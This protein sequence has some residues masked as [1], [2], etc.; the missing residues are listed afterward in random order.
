M[1][2]K[3]IGLLL[4]SLLVIS[5]GARPLAGQA[6][7]TYH[8]NK[9]KVTKHQHYYV[10]TSHFQQYSWYL[11]LHGKHATLKHASRLT[12]TTRTTYTSYK[13]IQLKHGKTTVT[14]LGV[15]PNNRGQ[16]VW[17]NQHYL[18]AGA[19]PN[20]IRATKTA[21]GHYQQHG[22]AL[23]WYNPK[24]FKTL[25]NAD[26]YVTTYPFARSSAYQASKYQKTPTTIKAVAGSHLANFKTQVYLPITMHTTGDFSNPQSVVMTPHGQGM[27][28]MQTTHSYS[29]TGRVVYYDLAG[30]K[31]YGIT[32]THMDR[33]RRASHDRAVN[34]L[35][36]TDQAILSHVKVGPQ[37]T[38]GH[39]QS[40][41]YNPHNHQLWFI[42]HGGKHANLQRLSKT[43]LKPIKKISFH[44]N[45]KTSMGS[46]LTFDSHGTAYFYSAAPKVG[47]APKG[48]VKL[49]A[50][51]IGKT[52]VR[53]HLVMQGLRYSPGTIAQTMSYNAHRNRLY[54]VSNGSI[55]SLP[56]SHLGHLKR[57]AIESTMFQTTRE[58]EGLS[59]TSTG[60]AYLLVNRGAEVLK[61]TTNQF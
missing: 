13:R 7:T 46:V 59:F 52:T 24:Q 34:K 17:I 56:V 55:I 18:H 51:K 61:A 3:S 30:L 43:T 29:T 33:L 37:F 19:N 41:A 2:I 36:A 31:Q 25:R 54:L 38:T 23:D 11:G 40:L 49:F 27:Y 6:A 58:F 48:S 10:P 21:K 47:S 15:R 50:G 53:F 1:Q 8:V 57:S 45:A 28:I 32:S 35:T 4:G 44:L 60:G 16:V 5:G 20:R 9:L 42:G 22:D 14:L 26:Y 12:K 39:G